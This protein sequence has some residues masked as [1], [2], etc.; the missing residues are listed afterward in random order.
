MIAGTYNTGLVVLSVLIA[1]VASYAAFNL[2]ERVSASNGQ[3]RWA[4]LTSGAIAMGFAIWSMHYVGMLAF[5]L[6]VPVLYHVP[7]VSLSL[8]A[9]VP[10]AAVALYIVSKKTMRRVNAA[11][12]G[13][14][15]GG[16]IVAMHYIGMAAMRSAAMHHYRLSL[17][18]LSVVV[19][20]TFSSV[21]AW[22]AF[23]FG[24]FHPR[25]TWTKIS[26]ASLM[27]LGIAS[28]HYTAMAAAYFVP[29]HTPPIRHT[30]EVSTL[31]AFG[32]G[33]TTLLLLG[34]VLVTLWWDRRL[35]NER[36]LQEAARR[37]EQELRDVINT[38]PAHA[39][40]ALL[41]GNIDFVNQRWQQFTGLPP[42][43]ALGWNWEVVLHPDDRAK[44][45]A[46]WRA[47]LKSG[48]PMETEVRVRRADGEYRC[49]LVRNVPLRNELGYIIKWYGTGLD[50]E[51]RKRTESLLAGEKRVLEMLAKG[52]SLAE[53]LDAL[54]RLVEEQAS[55][56]LASILLLDGDRLRHSGAPSLPK[57]Y[58]DAI[59]GAVIGPSAGSCGTAAYRGE[60][61][62]VED[63]A[64][65][66]LWA[67]YR[68]LALPH[69]LRA[70]WSTPVFSSQ[71]KVIAT[72]AMYYREPK[73]PSPRDQEIIEQITHLAGVAIERKLTQEA[74]RRS[75]TYLAE[76][77][78]LTHTGSWVWDVRTR[79]ATYL[80]DEWYRI[81]G[82]QPG[83]NA[84]A[85]EDRLQLIHPEDRNKWE[86]AINRAIIEKSDYEFDYRLLF[87]DGATKYIHVVGHPVLNAAG[88]VVQFM[89]SATDITERKQSEQ[90]LRRSEAYLAEAQKLTHTGSWA[91][92]LRT[93]ELF[94]SQE[95]F[96][97]YEI[98][99]QTKATWSRASWSR[100]L[101]RV[102]PEDRARIEQQAKMES[103]E[104]NWAVSEIEFRVVVSDGTIKHVHAISYRVPDDSG[105]TTEVMGTIMD[106]T[107]RK[108]A[109][110]ERER[111]HKLEADLARINRVS[112]MGE[113]AAS[114]AHEIKQPISAALTNAK[115]C[116]R[117][118]RRD[119][120][121]VAEACEAAARMVNDTTRAA[122]I[123]DRVR[124]LYS[125]DNSKR[126]LLDLNEIIREMIV[127]L[128]ER[129]SRTSISIRSE[130][131]PGVPLIT[132]DRVQ[133]QQV[134]VNLMLNGIEAMKDVS[135]ELTITSKR[136]EDGQL[137]ISV[138][139]SG[140]GIAPG[141]ANKIFDAFFTTKPQGT[142]MGLSIS[143][144]IIES[145][146]G[147]IWAIANSGRGTSFQF[148]LPTDV[149]ASSSSAA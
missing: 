15:L 65:D 126:E 57:A 116:M 107:E 96:R 130:L 147:R 84:R 16:A 39:W 72:F 100:F 85:W 146:G 122:E 99:P 3:R 55:G 20:I 141:Q 60:Q 79:E 90:A 98:D 133:L 46:D 19:A 109:E 67:A 25:L 51:D 86:A 129:T 118:L 26:G 33:M 93:G 54:C 11:I 41:D 92:N 44:F 10:G 82:L 132:A 30:V 112:M 18:I 58:M 53:I 149:T 49:L 47:A 136:T 121:D 71:G 35:A 117:W 103:T 135:G 22:L 104:K 113:L 73:R 42:E 83:S 144:R 76:A 34:T 48:Q 74:L 61:V 69:S 145:H 31:G 77:Q 37:S 143:R 7:T 148:T 68:D 40:S 94:W 128:H 89:G 36:L 102:H 97:I 134:L 88:D 29:G 12:A 137:M 119:T 115:T 111:L 45:V 131:D 9:A 28:M 87:P 17:V 125:R 124:S 138:S 32:I 56:V 13:L 106:V 52:N 78:K 5:V 62:I 142:G 6:P 2:G 43:D 64:T 14:C 105:D 80:S 114:L 21:A 91:W 110:T 95:V 108:R 8:I 50:I 70:C 1:I 4:W 24:R 120:P 63:I 66:P 140:I 23:R 101:D 81:Y 123:I 38:V 59:D 139:D 75:E 27:G 127:L